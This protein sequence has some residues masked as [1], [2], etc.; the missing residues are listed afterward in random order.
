MP[1]HN[2]LEE[3]QNLEINGF[4][5]TKDVQTDVN[6]QTYARGGDAYADDWIEIIP[7]MSGTPHRY[8]VRFIKDC[9]DIGVYVYD[10]APDKSIKEWLNEKIG[11]YYKED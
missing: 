2:D 3:V 5:F 8:V 6:T 10:W 11:M 1:K 7:D 9:S 4:E